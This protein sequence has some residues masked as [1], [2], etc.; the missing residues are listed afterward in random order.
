MKVSDWPK[1][2][3]LDPVVRAMVVVVLAWFTVCETVLEVLA[4]NVL[5]TPA[6]DAVKLCGFP[7]T[8]KAEVER[9]ATPAPFSVPVPSVVAPSL[10]VT[11]PVGVVGPVTCA[12]VADSVVGWPKS[13]G[14][15]ELVSVV[16]VFSTTTSVPVFVAVPAWHVPPP[17]PASTVSVVEPGGVAFAVAMVR[18]E[19][20]LPPVLVTELGLNDAVAPTGSAVVTLRGEVH[21]LPFPLKFTVTV[22]AVELPGATGFGD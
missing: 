17:F 21:E 19:F 11:V 1:T 22:N 16:A 13:D 7:A 18:V 10:K 9:V 12:T 15:T 20:T 6:Y 4:P 2:D 14:F 3:G 8:A 5:A